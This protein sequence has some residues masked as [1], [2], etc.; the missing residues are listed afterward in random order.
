MSTPVP[1]VSCEESTPSP[2]R[3][4][5]DPRPLVALDW[6]FKE[7]HVT[8]DGVEVVRLRS[9]DDLLGM[10][11]VPYKIVAESTFESWDP[12]RRRSIVDALRAAGHEIYVFRP[13]HTARARGSAATAKSDAN[14]ARTIHALATRSRLHVYPLPDVD[15]E[16]VERRES[17]NR[18]Y[19]R[20]RLSGEKDLLIES[21]VTALGPYRLLD[22][23]ARSVLGNGSTYSRSLLAAVFFASQRAR[24]RSEFER[25]LGLHGS[26]YPSLLRS[27]VHH[28]SFRFARRRGVTWKVYRRELRRAFTRLKA[29]RPL[30][31]D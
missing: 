29:L 8:F 10:L 27:E 2:R 17:A 22:D 11:T 19:Q 1:S 16:W 24:S 18:E 12:L 25:L 15:P 23:D 13:I 26:A 9:F 21:A 30:P 6:S 7:V 3:V 20:I 31:V 5:L 14:D 4:D 28:H